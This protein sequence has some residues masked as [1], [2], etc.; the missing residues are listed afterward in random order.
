MRSQVAGFIF[1]VPRFT[2]DRLNLY[3]NCVPVPRKSL[4]L[5][6]LLTKP[7]ALDRRESRSQ[8]GL[9]KLHENQVGETQPES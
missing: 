4:R 3:R 6:F 5:G 2:L 9:Q 8:G 7:E 1:S